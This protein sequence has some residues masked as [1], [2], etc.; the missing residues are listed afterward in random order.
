M[1]RVIVLG[2]GPAG[3]AAALELAE[4]GIQVTLLE[5]Q[6][7]VGGNA[8][9]FSLAGFNVDYGS[10][11]LHPASDPRVLDRIKELLGEDLLVRPR[12]GPVQA[13]IPG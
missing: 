9:S 7:R 12:H 1:S 11:R 8:G 10:H 4:R 6:D 2:G 3:L 13:P 5:R